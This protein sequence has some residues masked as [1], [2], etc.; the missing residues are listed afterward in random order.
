MCSLK[1]LVALALAAGA[2][3]GAI[4]DGLQQPAGDFV[5]PQWQARRAVLSARPSSVVLWNVEELRTTSDARQTTL[6]LGDHY[7]QW[8]GWTPPLG[9]GSF[10]ASSGLLIGGTRVAAMG[11]PGA[12]VIEG[13]FAAPYVGLGYSGLST[14]GG[15]GLTADVGLIVDSATTL[16]PSG[17]A[18]LGTQVWERAWRDLRPSPLLQLGV[19]YTF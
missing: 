14:K 17:R 8:A 2:P 16:Q 13:S 9:I 4:A 18:M 3:P 7:F 10:R 11:G 5:W 15:W 1:A 12:G 19:T 6:L